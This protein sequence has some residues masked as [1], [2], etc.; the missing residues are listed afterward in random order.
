MVEYLNSLRTQEQG[1]NA[2]YIH[3]QRAAFLDGLRAQHSWFPAD[4]ELHVATKLDG[5]GAAMRDRDGLGADLVFLTGDAG[6]GKTALCD[7]LAPVLADAPIG[8]DAE[9]IAGDWLIV[10]DASEIVEAR[11]RELIHERLEGTKLSPIM[12]LTRP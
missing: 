7:V 5:L 8:L 1:S 3:E 4:S 11:L 12:D 9:T 2:S 10:K 6:D